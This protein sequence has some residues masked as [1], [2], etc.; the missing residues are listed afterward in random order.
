MAT[1]VT[2]I[3]LRREGDDAVVLAEING[4]F[5]EVIRERAEGPFSHIV[6]DD[7]MQAIADGRDTSVPARA[8][9]SIA[10]PPEFSDDEVCGYCGRQPGEPHDLNRCR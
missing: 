5:V 3:W 9:F 2:G 10:K 4:S 1:E 7:G 8:A 6:E